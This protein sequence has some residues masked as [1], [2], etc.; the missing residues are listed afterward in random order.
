MRAF[1]VLQVQKGLHEF[2][3]KLFFLRYLSDSDGLM[4]KCSNK[5]LYVIETLQSTN[6]PLRHA[7]RSVSVNLF[8]LVM[9]RETSIPLNSPDR[10]LAASVFN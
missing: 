8:F 3:F 6:D 5:H 10:W 9:S 2:L 4:W 7:S 1:D